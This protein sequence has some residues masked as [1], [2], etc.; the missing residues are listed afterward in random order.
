MGQVDLIRN[1]SL[2]KT[3]SALSGNEQFSSQVSSS[4]STHLQTLHRYTS[5]PVQ[6]CQDSSSGV[7]PQ[8]NQQESAG[9]TRANKNAKRSAYLNKAKKKNH[10]AMQ[11]N[12]F[13]LTVH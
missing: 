9:E 12:Q 8:L 11:V 3:P 6:E 10:L 13:S 1:C 2:E 4:S 5:N 7:R